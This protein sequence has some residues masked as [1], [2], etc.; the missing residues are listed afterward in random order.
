M[1]EEQP[2]VG[3]ILLWI[4]GI[5]VVLFVLGTIITFANGGMD[6]MYQKVFGVPF[7]NVRRQNYEHTKSYE[8][9]SADRLSNLCGQVDKVDADHKDLLREQIKQEFSDMNTSD[10]P[11][12]LQGCLK[13]ARAH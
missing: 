3:K 10:A 2:S 9:G 7:E 1:S 8:K 11:D 6:L 5:F 12:Y 4:V 13:A